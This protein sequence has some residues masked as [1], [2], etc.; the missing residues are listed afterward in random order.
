MSGNTGVTGVERATVVYPDGSV[1]LNE[2]SLVA[3][4]GEILTVLGPS[5]SGK[6]TLLR[7]I[8]GLV[9]LRSGRVLIDGEYTVEVTGR[10]EVSMVFE[11][12]H[13]IPFLDVAKNMSFALDVRHVRREES[14]P[15]VE[16]QARRLRL[17]NVLARKPHTLSRGEQS[18]VGIGRALV[19]SPKAFLLDEPLA[20]LDAGER[21]RM[22]R[23]L[24]EV[25]KQ[26]GVTAIYITHDQT[27]ALTIGD[28]VAV[29]NAG[30]V[31]QVASGRT[32]YHEPVNAFVADFVGDVPIGFMSARLVVSAGMAGF[33][34]GTQILPTW[35]PPPPAL[36]GYRN[37]A[38]LL[39]IRAEDVFEQPAPEHGAVTAV[40]TGMELTGRHS[41]VGLRIGD[42]VLHARFDGRTSVRIGDTVTVGIDAAR[43]HVFDPASRLA[44]SHPPG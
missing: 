4:P 11:E 32:L 30:Q 25:I 33:Q 44:L 8:A 29:L 38:V 31:V 1:A 39:G 28:R 3:E 23:H 42:Q 35:L 17:G 14:R 2:A 26:A 24:C 6:S 13:L 19:R 18:R 43:A 21:G 22:R 36:D 16:E 15:R 34:L 9:S 41:I 5:G 27:D 40:V 7:A 10:R 37:N 12:A 20:H